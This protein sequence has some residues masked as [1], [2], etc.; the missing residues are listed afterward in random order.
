MYVIK[1]DKGSDIPKQIEETKLWCENHLVSANLDRSSRWVELIA[2]MQR[3][4]HNK[5]E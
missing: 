2:W 5:V 3:E 1:I 4:T